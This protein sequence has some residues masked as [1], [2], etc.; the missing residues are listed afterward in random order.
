MCTC[1][2]GFCPVTLNPPA[3]PSLFHPTFS[4]PFPLQAWQCFSVSLY[5]SL[6]SWGKVL[7][8]RL[9]FHSKTV[10]WM[11][12][13]CM[14]VSVLL[15]TIANWGPMLLP[16]CHIEGK[17]F[18][19][20]ER[21]VHQPVKILIWTTGLCPSSLLSIANTSNRCLCSSLLLE[22]LSCQFAIKSGGHAA[23]TGAPNIQ[24]GMTINL[25]NMND[26]TISKDGTQT[27]IG[28]GNWW[29]DIY[30]KLDPLTF[31]LL[32]PEF[33]IL[34]SADSQLVVAYR[35]FLEGIALLATIWITIRY[36]FISSRHCVAV[37]SELFR[38]EMTSVRS[39]LQM[40]YSWRQ[41]QN[42][43]WSILGL[44]RRWEQFRR[45]HLILAQCLPTRRSVGW[46]YVLDLWLQQQPRNWSIWRSD[47]GI[48]LYS[49]TGHVPHRVPV[50]VRQ[51][52]RQ[53]SHFAKFYQDPI[54]WGDYAD[55]ESHWSDGGVALVH[56]GSG[57]WEVS[58]MSVME[59]DK[60]QTN[61]LDSDLQEHCSVNFSHTSNLRGGDQQDQ[62]DF[63]LSPCLCIPTNQQM[64]PLQFRQQWWECTRDD[65]SRWPIKS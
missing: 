34:E 8:Y 32:V 33:Q 58:S 30:S 25:I 42:I 55:F 46:K 29:S 20:L 47:I 65:S 62:G 12:I 49:S 48:W 23:F 10:E 5:S 52:S 9:L 19:P 56:L 27:S 1:E 16:Q 4:F 43:P 17:S 28:P 15:K 37:C 14:C 3:V 51:T 41:S 21:D 63:R 53:S 57:K 39:P 22:S 38:Q 45:S 44:T 54:Y 35:S 24:G 50:G 61:L 26:I 59:A 2:V 64:H 31:P 7:E 60:L 13:Y 11:R 18:I 40:E 6:A 36:A